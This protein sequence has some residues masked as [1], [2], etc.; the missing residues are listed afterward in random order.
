MLL[1]IIIIMMSCFD[2]R[3]I[4]T[5]GGGRKR[6]FMRL[7]V[8]EN[9][10]SRRGDDKKWLAGGEV[11][12]CDAGDAERAAVVGVCGGEVVASEDGVFD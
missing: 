5:C 1:L 4:R 8:D 11:R 6:G 10:W 3:E 12:E 7:R 9:G 2:W